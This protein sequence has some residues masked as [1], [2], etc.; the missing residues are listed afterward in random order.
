MKLFLTRQY[1][2]D[3]CSYFMPYMISVLESRLRINRQTEQ[4]LDA[5]ICLSVLEDLDVMFQRKTLTRQQKFTIKLK[6]AEA[7]I[8]MKLMMTFPIYDQEF[9]RLNLRNN[10]VEQLH[11]QLV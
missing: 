6:K 5:I 3:I 4:E 2:E 7:V 11:K 9:W 8:L 1:L 10:I